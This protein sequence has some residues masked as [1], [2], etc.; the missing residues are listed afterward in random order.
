M[1][2]TVHLFNIA[3]ARLGGGQV[4]VN[5]SP[6]EDDTLGMLC[7]NLFPQVLDLTLTAHEWAF[8]I[9]RIALG[10]VPAPVPAN[11]AYR[12]AYE[13]PTDCVKPVRLEGYAGVNRS[14]VYV[15]E[16]STLRT[17]QERAVLVYVSRVSDPLRWP[18]SFADALAWGLA[19]ELAAARI[20]DVQRQQWCYQNY[21]IALSDAIARDITS[22]NPVPPQSEWKNARYR[23]A[24]QRW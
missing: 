17:N 20:N 24:E 6:Q 16:G 19:G 1:Q 3:V 2:S 5:I 13:L 22:Q 23:R 14:P 10:L 8:A 18:P 12:L 9:T 4:P 7:K 11:E 21:K 15:I